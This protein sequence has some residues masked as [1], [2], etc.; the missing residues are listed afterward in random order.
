ME[1]RQIPEPQFHRH[2]PDILQVLS[3]AIAKE[4]HVGA[5]DNVVGAIARLI[6]AN[7]SILPLDQI[8][9]VFVNQLPLKEDFE[10]NKAVFKSILTLYEA[11]HSILQAHMHVLLK[12]A[13]SVLYEESATDDGML[14]D[15]YI[16][17]IYISTN[18]M[19][20]CTYVKFQRLRVLLWNSSNLHS[21][22]FQ[23]NGIPCTL[24]SQQ[25]LRRVFNVYFLNFRYKIDKDFVP[26]CLDT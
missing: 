2:Y 4:S 10:E 3:N 25:R 17:P 11:G 23:M 9:P 26:L 5:R 24:N 8:F 6:I 19:F 18:I 20:N 1:F 14:Y 13:V 12:V 16:L 21:E 22:I 7:Y 15:N